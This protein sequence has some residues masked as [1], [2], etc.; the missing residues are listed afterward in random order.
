MSAVLGG[1]VPALLASTVADHAPF[2]L[3]W[4]GAGWGG[5]LALLVSDLFGYAAHRTLHNVPFLWRWTHP[6]R[7]APR[8][9]AGRSFPRRA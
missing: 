9:S 7:A 4:L 3:G 5:R 8:R 6:S 1:V 2:K